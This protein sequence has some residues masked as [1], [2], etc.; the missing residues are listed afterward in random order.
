[1][2]RS[3]TPLYS[4]TFTSTS[5]RILRRAASVALA[6]GVLILVS[7]TAAQAHVQVIADQTAAG[8]ESTK[9]SFRVPTESE[10]ASTVKLVVSMPTDTPLAEVLVEPLPG[11]TVAVTQAKLPKPVDLDGTTLTEAPSTVTWTAT[12]GHGVPPGGFQEFVLSAGPIPDDAK[13]LSFPTV[14]TYSDGSVVKWNQ[15][16]AAGA[17]EPEN[18]LPSFTVTAAEPEEGAAAPAAT[19][20]P[21]ASSEPSAA[22]S[23]ATPATSSDS[24]SSDSLGRGLGAAGLIAGLIGLAFGV[25]AWRR[26][27]GPAAVGS[28]S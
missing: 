20:T 7:G 21:A 22:A 25:L 10:K 12:A 13:V 6:L 24:S 4:P 16:Q 27:T 17:D 1:M 3:R 15:P 14:Q 23:A 19:A 5:P 11:W 18:P 8:S 28:A 9:L 2:P 26:S